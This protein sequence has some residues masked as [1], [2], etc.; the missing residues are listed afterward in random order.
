[1]YVIVPFCFN[2][3]GVTEKSFARKTGSYS[4]VNRSRGLF[5][6]ASY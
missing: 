3:L 1:M 2:S 6:F 5:E 4:K